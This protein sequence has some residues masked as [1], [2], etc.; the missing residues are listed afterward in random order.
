MFTYSCRSCRSRCFH[1]RLVTCLRM[2]MKEFERRFGA[3][4]EDVFILYDSSRSIAEV[5]RRTPIV[6]R[7]R[8]TA[9][10]GECYIFKFLAKIR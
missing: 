1:N 8:I 3:R 7:N 10:K 4:I 5:R 9:A 2:I 6:L